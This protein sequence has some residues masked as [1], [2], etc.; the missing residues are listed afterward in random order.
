MRGVV[1]A[2]RREGSAVAAARAASRRRARRASGGANV[3]HVVRGY[4]AGRIEAQR[5][6]ERR[7]I[8]P[9]RKQ[10]IGGKARR[11]QD[12]GRA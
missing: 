6:V 11:K 10:G 7:R 9:S 5:L 1:R 4:D 12:H 8:L 2:G 3:K